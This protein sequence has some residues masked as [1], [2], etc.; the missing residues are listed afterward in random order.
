MWVSIPNVQPGYVV[1]LLL[2]SQPKTIIYKLRAPCLSRYH[3]TAV[4]D[5]SKALET[6]KHFW[7]C[8][9]G[10]SPKL[11]DGLASP[12]SMWQSPIENTIS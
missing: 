2:T 4:F 3:R 6:N 10:C 5:L 9:G 1:R 8:F 11:R 7:S 12:L